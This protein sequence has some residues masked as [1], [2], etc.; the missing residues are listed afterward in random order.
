VVGLCHVQGVFQG[1]FVL[2]R[3]IFIHGTSV[4]PIPG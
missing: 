4:G 2:E 1:G 3:R